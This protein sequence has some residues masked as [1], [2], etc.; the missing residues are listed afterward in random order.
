MHLFSLPNLLGEC[1]NNPGYMQVH[2]A[3]V[4][5]SCEQLLIENRCPISEEMYKQNIWIPG[6]VNEYF[7][8]LTTQEK[9]QKYEPRVLS[10]PDYL[11]GDTE[12]TADYMVNGPWAVMLENFLSAEEAERLIELGMEEGYERSS[13]V[14]EIKY[15]GSHER[16]VNNGRTSYNS[17]CSGVCY[18]DTI[19]KGV[20]ER[21]TEVTNIPEENSE[22][23]VSLPSV[24][25]VHDMLSRASYSL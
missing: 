25:D 23:L 2:C 10:R 18:N 3:P 12:E 17:W 11:P 22:W 5:E 13:D 21:I 1:D 6:D 20:I 19:V 15:D 24:S 7:T 8:N 16:N 4:C 9:F 14:G